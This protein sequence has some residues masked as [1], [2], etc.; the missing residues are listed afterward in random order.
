M[1]SNYVTVS[2]KI[3]RDLWVRLKKQ[4]IKISEVIRRALEEELRKKEK[5]ELKKKLKKAGAILAIHSDDEIVELIRK[6]RDER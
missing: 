2:A 5:E 6:S 1:K 3:K 4:N